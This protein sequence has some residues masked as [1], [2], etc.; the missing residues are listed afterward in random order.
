MTRDEAFK[1]VPFRRPSLAEENLPAGGKRITVEVSPGKWQK[2]IL[3]LPDK[4]QQN[5]EFDRMGVC[6][7]DLCD[8]KRNV[9]QIVKEFA[10]TFS[11]DEVEAEKAVLTFLKTLTTKGVVDLMVP[12]KG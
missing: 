5:Y 6:F 12:R 7:L 10:T 8:S 9:R 2:R 3:R 1:V 4:I 11:L